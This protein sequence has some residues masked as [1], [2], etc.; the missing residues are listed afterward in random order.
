LH[1]L[2]GIPE[3][4]RGLACR[5]PVRD[6]QCGHELRLRPVGDLRGD[7]DV[8]RGGCSAITAPLAVEIV[9]DIPVILVVI[10]LEILDR[11]LN[12]RY[13]LHLR[14]SAPCYR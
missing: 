10:P 7:P 11:A 9:V 13:G 12:R 2:Q 14:A 6:Q 5:D 3:H 1:P 4:Y 8:S